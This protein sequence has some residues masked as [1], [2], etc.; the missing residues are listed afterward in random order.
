MRLVPS[1]SGRFG[2]RR[3]RRGCCRGS[4]STAAGL[5]ARPPLRP[6]PRPDRGSRPR[7]PVRPDPANAPSHPSDAAGARQP[8]SRHRAKNELKTLYGL[9][10]GL[11]TRPG[12]TRYGEPVACSGMSPSAS[13]TCASRRRP[14]GVKS[15]DTNTAEAPMFLANSRNSLVGSAA[16]DEQATV[17]VVTQLSQGVAHELQPSPSD[18]LQPRVEHETREHVDVAT[19]C[20]DQ[21]GQIPQPQIAA[22]P[23]QGRHNNHAAR[24]CSAGNATEL[25]ARRFRVSTVA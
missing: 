19:C 25:G 24:K 3:R 17:E 16:G 12:D 5:P 15:A 22:E 7:P 20:V 14:N 1:L 23:Q 13:R 2:N 6:S 9:P 4:G 10:S 18:F 8:T 21:R 11:V